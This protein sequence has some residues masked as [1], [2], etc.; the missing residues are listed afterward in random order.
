MDLFT[1]ITQRRSCRRFSSDP[2]DESVIGRI[3]EAAAWAPSPL[4]AQPWQFIVITN[5][6]KKQEIFAEAQRC[7][8]WACEKSGWTWLSK[9]AIDF[10]TQAPVIVAVVGD[11]KKTGMD[12]FQEQGPMAYQHACAAAVQNM[13]LAAHALGLGSLWFTLFDKAALRAILDV[14]T[15]KTPIALVCI[16]K[17]EAPPAPVPRKDVK[18]KTTY[19]R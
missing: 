17:P 14:P 6:A 18:G 2:V 13:L 9:Y 19:L 11:P 15:E 10:L 4:N 16:G 7:R 3:L 12:Q 5:A 1:A 8:Q